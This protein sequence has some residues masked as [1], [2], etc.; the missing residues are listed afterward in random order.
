MKKSK[1]GQKNKWKNKISTSE[2]L[3]PTHWI[4]PDVNTS[5]QEVCCTRGDQKFCLNTLHKCFAR[6]VIWIPYIHVSPDCVIWIPSIHVSQDVLS[7]YL[8]YMFREM[9]Y[10]NTLHL[11]FRAKREENFWFE[12]LAKAQSVTLGKVWRWNLNL[13]LKLSREAPRKFLI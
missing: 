10:L 13:K 1:G 12:Y 8:A 2:C 9:C 3:T 5:W 4:A 11:N 7:E 6:C